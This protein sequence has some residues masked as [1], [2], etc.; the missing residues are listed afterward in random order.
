MR[1]IVAREMGIPCVV[2][3]GNAVT[4]ISTG[5]RLRLDAANGVVLVLDTRTESASHG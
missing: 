2:N 5:M 1:Q 4:R 3:T